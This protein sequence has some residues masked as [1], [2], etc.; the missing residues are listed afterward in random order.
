MRRIATWLLVGAVAA[1][2]FAAAVDALRGDVETVREARPQPTT[3]PVPGLTGRAGPAADRLR[4]ARVT[5]V[6]TYADDDCRLSAV[7]LPDLKQLPWVVV[8]ES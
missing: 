4:E 1:L 8:A 3:T 5:G 6:L 2:G 7:S